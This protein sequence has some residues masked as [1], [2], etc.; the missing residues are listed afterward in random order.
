MGTKAAK[1]NILKDVTSLDVYV[2]IVLTYTILLLMRRYSNVK[3]AE[4]CGTT[5]HMWLK[6]S[7]T[8]RWFNC[9]DW[10]KNKTRVF[11]AGWKFMIYDL[12]MS[13]VIDVICHLCHSMTFGR[14]RVTTSR[15]PI[16]VSNEPSGAQEYSFHKKNVVGC[17]RNK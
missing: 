6:I 10:I 5:E 7:S 8:I 12:F 3:D 16:W 17:N 11:D 4:M 14:C 15:M 13:S 2:H 9:N 1:V